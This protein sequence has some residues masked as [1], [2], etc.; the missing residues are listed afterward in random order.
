MILIDFNENVD[1][2]NF[3][4]YNLAML[5]KLKIAH[6]MFDPAISFLGIC[7][8]DILALG[9]LIY[10]LVKFTD[11]L[12]QYIQENISL[13]HMDKIALCHGIIFQFTMILLVFLK[14]VF[15]QHFLISTIFSKVF[16]LAFWY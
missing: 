16:F 12:Y 7:S 15:F 10:R 8:T 9:Q 13:M 2:C 3:L 11:S 1:W 14:I 5:S 6:T 4:K